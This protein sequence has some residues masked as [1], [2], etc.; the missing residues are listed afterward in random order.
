M[1]PLASSP[2]KAS[3]LSRLA[4]YL[5]ETAEIFREA[6]RLREEFRRRHPSIVD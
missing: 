1:S 4:N 3:G 6:G 5:R 2:T